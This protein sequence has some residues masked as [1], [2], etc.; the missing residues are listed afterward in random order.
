MFLISLPA[1]YQSTLLCTFVIPAFSL[2]P[3][4]ALLILA[5][6]R[7]RP[8]PTTT[9]VEDQ[10]PFE[11]DAF[12]EGAHKELTNKAP[13]SQSPPRK[14]PRARKAIPRHML[15]MKKNM[16]V[17]GD[18]WLPA[19]QP[20]TAGYQQGEIDLSGM[21]TVSRSPPPSYRTTPP[22]RTT[23]LPL[24]PVVMSSDSSSPN[25]HSLSSDF[26]VVDPASPPPPAP[27]QFES[28]ALFYADSSPEFADY[29][30][31]F[32]QANQGPA[33]SPFPEGFDFSAEAAS[34]RPNNTHPAS[35][36]VSSFQSSSALDPHSPFPFSDPLAH[37]EFAS[38]SLFASAPSG[39]SDPNV[40]YPVPGANSYSD[41]IPP[42]TA[43][44]CLPLDGLFPDDITYDPPL[45]YSSP[46]QNITTFPTAAW[47]TNNGPYQGQVAHTM[48]SVAGYSNSQMYTRPGSPYLS[49]ADGQYSPVYHR[50]GS[51]SP[52]AM[53]SG[54]TP[55]YYAP[56]SPLSTRTTSSGSVAS[57][58]NN[59]SPHALSQHSMSSCSEYSDY[60]GYSSSPHSA[61][62]TGS[63]ASAYSSYGGYEGAY[64]TN[65]VAASRTIP[66][67]FQHHSPTNWLL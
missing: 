28:G 7:K 4:L 19:I 42:P 57:M 29:F 11:Q 47:K 62:L 13:R 16:S 32:E 59:N 36:S 52:M 49:V 39:F 14:K 33:C 2:L 25:P 26:K 63:P 3:L 44:P 43:Q 38:E 41:W 61:V 24:S 34:S 31:Q 8:S 60:Y 20:S 22:H 58:C 30:G 67:P 46:S 15:H 18:R 40:A 5:M 50:A 27:S 10:G 54:Q 56:L 66:L 12:V 65:T 55:P 6:K 48:P 9:D 35:A 37:I 23:P 64:P 53:Y 17:W 21:Y 1:A 45:P 51:G